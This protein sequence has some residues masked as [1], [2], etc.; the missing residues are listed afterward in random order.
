MDI[1]LM[2]LNTLGIVWYRRIQEK[3]R[4]IVAKLEGKKERER[5][6]EMIIMHGQTDKEGYRGNVQWQ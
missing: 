4:P 1:S 5:I 6:K 3:L 2:I